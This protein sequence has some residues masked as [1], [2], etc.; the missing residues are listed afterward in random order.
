MQCNICSKELA[1]SGGTTNLREHLVSK[2]PLQYQPALKSTCSAGSTLTQ[3]TLLSFT[4]ATCCSEAQA[5]E[6]TERIC[7]MIALDTRPI[8][9]VEGEGFHQLL[10]FLEPGYT[11]PSRKQFTAMVEHK[12]GLGKEKLKLQLKEEAINVALTTDIWTSTAVE[13]YM[14]VILHYINPNWDMQAFAFLRGTQESL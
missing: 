2:H 9:M 8:R 3:A 4:K 5:K 11:I 14:T 12:H 10:D 7:E 13:A 1:Y 6:I